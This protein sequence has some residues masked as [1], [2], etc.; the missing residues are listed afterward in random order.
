MG[1]DAVGGMSRILEHR[2]SIASTHKAWPKK[3]IQL[4]RRRW[5]VSL[6]TGLVTLTASTIL[7]QQASSFSQQPVGGSAVLGDQ[8]VL[9]IGVVGSTPLSIQWF[10]DGV[11]IPNANLAASH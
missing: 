8:M 9:N 6:A 3:P 5:L 10:H 2:N 7:A 11:A 1:S 4:P